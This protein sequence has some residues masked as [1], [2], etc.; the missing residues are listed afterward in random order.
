M[1]KQEMYVCLKRNIQQQS[2]E[3][4]HSFIAFCVTIQAVLR[5]I[6]KGLL[7][8]IQKKSTDNQI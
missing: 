4:F 6:Q 2:I 8:N 5:T 3:K 7:E 1:E